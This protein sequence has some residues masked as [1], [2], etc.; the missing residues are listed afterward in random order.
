MG[1]GV[2]LHLLSDKVLRQLNDSD[3]V[4]QVVEPC[5]RNIQRGMGD[6]VVVVED[7]VSEGSELDRGLEA[8]ST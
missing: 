4:T 5:L 1:T 6:N 2:P 3:V 8:S 7:P